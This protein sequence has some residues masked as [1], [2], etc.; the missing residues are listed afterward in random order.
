MPDGEGSGGSRSGGNARAPGG[1]AARAE[2]AGGVSAEVMVGLPRLQDATAEQKLPQNQTT[3][4][5]CI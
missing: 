2:D 5:D 4:C 1:D 3:A